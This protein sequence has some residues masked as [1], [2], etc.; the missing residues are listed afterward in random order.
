M[1][2]I[3][4]AFG[5]EMYVITYLELKERERYKLKH[6]VSLIGIGIGLKIIADSFRCCIIAEFN[7]SRKC[8]LTIK[9]TEMRQDF[10][11]PS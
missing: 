6:Y 5:T 3:K 8:L 2:N 9:L 4:M 7:D 11:L 1:A 10:I